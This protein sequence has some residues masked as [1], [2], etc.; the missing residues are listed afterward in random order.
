MYSQPIWKSGQV[1]RILAI[2]GI[3]QPLQLLGLHAEN[4][5]KS[6]EVIKVWSSLT[7]DPQALGVTGKEMRM[8]E[9]Q[10]ASETISGSSQLQC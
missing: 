4:N 8:L 9:L 1:T 2:W 3:R 5:W 7:S 10:S 6:G